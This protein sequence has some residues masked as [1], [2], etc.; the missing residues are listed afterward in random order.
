M[1]SIFLTM[2]I[3]DLSEYNYFQRNSNKI[4]QP[5]KNIKLLYMFY[6]SIIIHFCPT[7][8]AKISAISG[9][10]ITFFETSPKQ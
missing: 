4:E 9:N 10:N 3:F 8:D 6:Y 7:K 2:L 5:T 1:F